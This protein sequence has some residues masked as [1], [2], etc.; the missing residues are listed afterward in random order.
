MTAKTTTITG[1]VADNDAASPPKSKRDPQLWGFLVCLWLLSFAFTLGFELRL[2]FEN[3]HLAAAAGLLAV[4]LALAPAAALFANWRSLRGV[5][6][7]RQGR[8]EAANLDPAPDDIA[9]DIAERA[10]SL[11]IGAR[12]S[13]F[14][15]SRTSNLVDAYAAGVGERQSMVLTGGVARLFR[16]RKPEDQAKY[17]FLIDHELGGV[18]NDGATV[19]HLASGTL[20]AAL[21]MLPFK[22]A[23]FLYFGWEEVAR[24]LSRQLPRAFDGGAPS[25]AIGAD[26]SLNFFSQYVIDGAY[27]ATFLAL[28]QASTLMAIWLV[29]V[30][31]VRRRAFLADRTAIE[32]APGH[33]EGLAALQSLLADAPLETSPPQ[34]FQAGARWRPTGPR[35]LWQAGRTVGTWIDDGVAALMLFVLIVIARLS[36]GAGSSADERLSDL[37]DP[38]SGLFFMLVGFAVSALL[39]RRRENGARSLGQMFVWMLG[40]A[41]ILAGALRLLQPIDDAG[42]AFFD[43]MQELDRIE[44]FDW[45]LLLLSVPVGFLTLG[46]AQ[47]VCQTYLDT[48]LDTLAGRFLNAAAGSVLAILAL[49]GLSSALEP[50]LRSDRMASLATYKADLDKALAASEHRALPR[51]FDPDN[52]AGAI[53]DAAAFERHLRALSWL[54]RQRLVQHDFAPPLDLFVFWRGPYR[55]E[56]R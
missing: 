56:I 1:G 44:R 12:L 16:S 3:G 32:A 22:V 38:I 21:M 15:L 33:T 8:V 45:M 48:E 47:L 19:L 2:L 53:R 55:S 46:A 51:A 5:V 29:Y 43:H 6:V 39:G 17:R 50:A 18:A 31:I 4:F 26:P 37:L 14:C 11:G 49:W 20:I 34:S 24:H 35:R 10:R 9:Y 40:Y 23:I 27:L 42:I 13:V 28:L 54:Y 30:A 25:P 36:F 41:I 7:R 52:R